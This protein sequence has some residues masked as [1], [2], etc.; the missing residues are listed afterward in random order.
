MT[1]YPLQ[2]DVEI[3]V[4]GSRLKAH[5]ATVGSHIGTHVDAPIHAIDG[6]K[7]MEE[8]DMARFRGT[9]VVSSVHREAG[10]V[11]TIADILA[12]GPEPQAG[13][14]LL[15]HTGWDKLFHDAVAYED[16]PWLADEVGPWAVAKGLNMVGIDCF[17]PDQPIE[18]RTDDSVF[19]YPIHRS[20]LGAEILIIE[21]L[22]NLAAASG[23]RG[24]FWAFPV[25]TL[26]PGG[27]A[28]HIRFMFEP[29]N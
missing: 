26:A 11:I 16:H 8:L 9:A 3:T 27:D 4:L 10:E 21:N 7:R 18:R 12:G 22:V 17:S 1:R 14:T 5:V 28:G 2:P 19:T 15:V 25:Y 29:I 20:L 13:E 23:K 24:N 6:G